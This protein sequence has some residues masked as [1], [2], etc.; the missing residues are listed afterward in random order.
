MKLY[1]Y[2][3]VFLA[4]SLVAFSGCGKPRESKPAAVPP[5]SIDLGSL[6]QAFPAPTPEVTSCLDKLRFAARYRQF[7]P[8][9][10][11]LNKLAQL[12]TLTEPQKQAVS[13]VIEQ[14]KVAIQTGPPVPSR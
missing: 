7:A 12:P 5:G 1:R 6:Q 2:L 4:A 11:E 8:A 3:L 14:V 10:A 9:L 13:N